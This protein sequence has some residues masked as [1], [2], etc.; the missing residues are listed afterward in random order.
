MQIINKHER[1]VKTEK[2]KIGQ[3]LDEI[4]I[5]EKTVWPRD[6]WP[7]IEFEKSMSVG[8]AG[9]HDGIRYTITKYIPGKYLE[10]KFTA[11]V[12]FI[13][14][15][16]FEIIEIDNSTCKISHIS[17]IT[18]KGKIRILWPIIMRPLHDAML[19]DLFDNVEIAA[20]LNPNKKRWS[21]WVKMLRKLYK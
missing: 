20:G 13:G 2:S 9:G 7:A 4:C 21:F 15:H 1:V 8:V 6:R 3:M 19:E 5:K 17:R 16:T 11:P 12:G 18:P 10:C 14:S